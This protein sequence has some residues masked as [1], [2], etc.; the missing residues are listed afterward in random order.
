MR[1]L[2]AE[3][4]A[5]IIAKKISQFDMTKPMDAT[6]SAGYRVYFSPKNILLKAILIVVKFSDQKIFHYYIIN[7]DGSNEYV[8]SQD[9]PIYF[10]DDRGKKSE[11]KV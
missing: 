10:Y 9:G 7:D 1:R 5:R 4:Q 8:G 6:G 3:K 2:S 11:Y